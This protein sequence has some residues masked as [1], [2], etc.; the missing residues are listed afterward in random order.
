MI[1]KAKE[2]K[3]TEFVPYEDDLIEDFPELDNQGVL[4]T[5]DCIVKYKN[6]WFTGNFKIDDIEEGKTF[7]MIDKEVGESDYLKDIYFF[8]YNCAGEEINEIKADQVSDIIKPDE[9]SLSFNVN[10][11]TSQPERAIR[12]F[13]SIHSE[14][15]NIGEKRFWEIVFD[16]AQHFLITEKETGTF[17]P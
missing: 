3:F 17:N 15:V 8:G 1:Q 9:L 4:H 2:L 16:T 11:D 12:N 5:E 14:H 7:N 13:L 6:E 10:Q